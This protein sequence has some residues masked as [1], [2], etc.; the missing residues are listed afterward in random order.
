MTVRVDFL[1]VPPPLSPFVLAVLR[2]PSKVATA[3]S[4][5]W[6]TPS[7]M[8]MSAE[9]LSDHMRDTSGHQF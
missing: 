4:R 3:L 8:V 1:E 9:W 2:L 6:R 5:L 7:T